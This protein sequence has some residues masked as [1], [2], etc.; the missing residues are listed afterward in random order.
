MR[1]SKVRAYCAVLCVAAAACNGRQPAPPAG[2]L[3][4]AQRVDRATAGRVK[5]KVV[6]EGTVPENPQIKMAADP[7]CAR[8]NA[9]GVSF[10]TIKVSD[11]G[12]DNAFV[13]VKGGLGNYYFETP[14]TAVKLDQKGCRYVP[15]VFGLRVGQPLEISNSD[16]TLHNVHA[17]PEVN[18]EFNFGQAFPGMKTT[19]TFTAPE[20][21]VP[22]K[23]DVHGWMT[24]YAGVLNHPYFAVTA[25]GG[26][27]ELND[28]P[29]GTYTVEAWH[30]KLGVRTRNV[31]IGEKESKD[32]LFTFNVQ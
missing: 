22:F 1:L 28:V 13:Y 5:G 6:F 30:E 24:S 15:H 9:S 26:T 4:D 8:E 12:L 11:G 18:Q 32:L 16:A 2:P 27:F 20:V 3:P 31:T 19:K 29:P 17:V 23:C 10:E 21:M 7:V 25:G 14:A